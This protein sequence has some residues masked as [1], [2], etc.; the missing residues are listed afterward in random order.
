IGVLINTL[1]GYFQRAVIDG[2]R[3]KAE[4]E[5]LKLFFFPGHSINSPFLFERQFNI[6]Y[7]LGNNPHVDAI[8]SATAYFQANLT[9]DETIQ[10]IQ[11]YRHLPTINLNFEMPGCPSVTIDNRTGFREL[12]QH[13]IGYHGYRR[14]AFMQGSV[15]NLDANERFE[16]Y[17]RCLADAGLTYDPRGVVK[18]NFN[19]FGGRTAMEELLNRQLP[20]D[21]LVAA[22]DGM[23]QAAMAVAVER[24]FRV[25]QDFAVTGF[26]DMLSLTKQGPALTTISQSIR[27]QSEVAIDI[28]LA[29]MRGDAVADITMVP[30]RMVLRQSCGCVAKFQLSQVSQSMVESAQP[31]TIAP[32]TSEK[33]LAALNLL[34]QHIPQYRDY[35]QQLQQALTE[36][37][38]VFEERLSQMAH[39]CL[40]QSGDISHLQCLLL[41]MYRHLGQTAGIANE[42]RQQ[43]GEYL[44][45]G[46]II[47][48]NAQSVFNVRETPMEDTSNLLFSEFGFLKRRMQGFNHD[49]MMNLIGESMREFAIPSAYIALYSTPLIFD[50]LNDYVLPESAQLIFAMTDYEPQYELLHT[51]FPTRN[52]V[53]AQL[54]GNQAHQAMALFP[55]CQHTKHYGYVIFDLTKMPACRVETIRDEISTNLINSILVAELGQARD[56]L[57]VDLDVAASLNVRLSDEI[58]DRKLIQA[59]LLSRN[60]E[61]T[62]LNKKL[63]QAQEQLM[64]S[65]KLASIGQLAAGVAHEINN[66]IGYIFSNLNSLDGYVTQV[67]DMLAAYHEAQ[68]FITAPEVVARLDTMRNDNEIDFLI[69][70]TRTLMSETK[71][72]ISRVRK[73]VQDL[74]DFSH[75]EDKLEWHWSNLHNG[76]DS[77]LNII[78]SEVKYKADVI[79]RYGDIADVE[80]LSSQINQ[81]IMNLVVN[82][83]HATGTA[84]GKITI[85]TGQDG[86]QVWIE[87]SDTGCGIPADNLNRIFD[88]FYTTKPIGKGTGLG[89]SLSYGIVQRHHGSIVVSSVVGQGT[90]FRVTLP[91]KHVEAKDEA[92]PP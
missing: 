77:T 81:V 24:G 14:L 82:A 31:T 5:G 68:K 83:A 19:Q 15:G 11:R 57:T 23:A 48:S 22:N 76:I 4:Q 16:V 17:K 65:E 69:D 89:L 45:S 56:L 30:T 53:P 74:K 27:Q 90:T 88:P 33:I 26:D 37:E 36:D 61:L 41:S 49:K 59:E 32:D 39:I 51:P 21:V 64:Q 70:D 40:I 44:L 9:R 62:E 43:F 18:G 54:F 60:S 92:A 67:F 80:C 50:S 20:F 42:E 47:L 38:A 25:P 10:F 87:V 2:L 72:G 73:I 8:I 29:K 3:K 34:P 91:I 86:E 7:D 66:P 12:L 79:K 1:D 55:I 13:L 52:L 35:L 78:A 58:T 6:V 75:V 46:Q 28:L 71:E 63:S 85:A 84:R